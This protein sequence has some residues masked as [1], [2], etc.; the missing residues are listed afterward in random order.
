MKKFLLIIAAAIAFAVSANAQKAELQLGYGG[1][2]QM[3]AMDMHDGWHGVNNAWGAVTAGV[4]FKVAPK[5]WIGPS[6]S[7]SST[8]TKGGA[9]ASHIAYHV[10]MLNARYEYYRNSIVKLYGHVGLGADISY[11]QPKGGD[12]FSKGYVAFQVSPLGAQVDLNRNV[13]LF[14]EIGFGAQGLAQVGFRFAL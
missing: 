8:S 5:F 9:N 3:D 6:Y 2:T 7:F 12:N 10:I 11:M 4:N 14:G 1:Y 13:A